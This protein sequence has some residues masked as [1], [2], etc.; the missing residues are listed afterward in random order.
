MKLV[1][2][3]N[4]IVSGFL[5][6]GIPSR[7]LDLI[8]ANSWQLCLTPKLL[9][10]TERVLHYERLLIPLFLSGKST[11]E[12]IGSLEQTG[13]VLPD[14]RGL[15][16]IKEDPTD[17]IILGAGLSHNVD[18]IISGDKHLLKLK[19]FQDVLIV[20]PRQFLNVIKR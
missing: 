10:E 11:N 2:D 16:I 6:K 8:K 4:V 7:I 20:S 19:S 17:N 14:C 15:K 5:W 9:E 3:T 12:I 1:I 13:V 18:Y